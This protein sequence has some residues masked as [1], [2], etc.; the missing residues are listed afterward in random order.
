VKLIKPDSAGLIYPYVKT[1]TDNA[2]FRM[3][4]DLDETVDI[5]LLRKAASDLKNRFP[6]L[7]VNLIQH[8]KMFMLAPAKP[9]GLVVEESDNV[10][11]AFDFEKQIPMR[12]IVYGNRMSVET[13]HML[14]D[15]HGALIFMKT[16]LVHY[17]NLK[18]S[19]KSKKIQSINHSEG[20]LYI[21]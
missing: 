10:C 20:H 8:N 16:L 5:E 4:A 9:C 3:E 2:V 6:G 21:Q 13:F 14:A 17:F 15:E 19:I 1:K 11:T 7:F 12:I 18:G